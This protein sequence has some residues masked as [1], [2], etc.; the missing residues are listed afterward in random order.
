MRFLVLTI[1]IF[2]M[3]GCSPKYV[4]KT[5]YLAP[6]T[7]EGINCI[8]R[9]E[10][11]RGACQKECDK[12]F[13]KCLYIAKKDAKQS[14][15]RELQEYDRAMRDYYHEMNSYNQEMDRF[16]YRKDKLEDDYSHFDARCKESKKKSREDKYSCRRAS[17]IDSELRSK[18]RFSSDEPKKPIRPKKPTLSGQIKKLQKNC[19]R[20]CGCSKSYDKC[21]SSCGGKLTY[22]KICIENCK[23]IQTK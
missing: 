16:Q 21:Y 17:D 18:Y 14:L 20:D 3:S 8:K 10:T 13:D 15:D 9:C 2:L 6:T 22:E 7:K 19:S 4:V 23:A 12:N 11:S 1:T 5:H